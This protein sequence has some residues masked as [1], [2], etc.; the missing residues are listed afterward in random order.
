MPGVSEE[1]V[2][3]VRRYQIGRRA[4]RRQATAAQPLRRQAVSM[5]RRSRSSRVVLLV[6]VGICIVIVVAVCW[7]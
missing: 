6:T 7:W 2:D 5:N 1:Q 4:A 3:N